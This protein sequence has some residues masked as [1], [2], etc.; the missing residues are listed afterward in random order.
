MSLTFEFEQE[1]DGRWVAEIIDDPGA[2]AYGDTQEE[3]AGKAEVIYKA[4]IKW[5]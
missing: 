2:L 5:A 1:K 4:I 3:A